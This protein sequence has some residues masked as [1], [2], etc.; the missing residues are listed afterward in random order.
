R[1]SIVRIIENRLGKE[2]P[3]A[4]VQATVQAVEA[5]FEVHDGLSTPFDIYGDW[6][7]L[8][9][10]YTHFE[11]DFADSLFATLGRAKVPNQGHCY[12][13]FL[14]RLLAIRT[15]FTFNFDDLIEQSLELEGFRPKVFAME[16]GRNLPH[17]WLAD[18]IVSVVKMH[19]GTHSL[20]LDE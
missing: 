16:E 11:T 5:Q 4:T 10:Y 20:L 15:V 13:T 6:R 14:I 18:D 9:Q 2:A 3:P 8:I 19:G 12:L 7:R 17:G 1:K